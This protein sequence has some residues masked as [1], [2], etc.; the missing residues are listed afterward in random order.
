MEAVNDITSNALSLLHSS[1]SALPLVR[2]EKSPYCEVTLMLLC[3]PKHPMA[4][5][6]NFISFSKEFMSDLP[7]A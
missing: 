4:G 3:M 6:I 2:R 1:F 7:Q 5:F